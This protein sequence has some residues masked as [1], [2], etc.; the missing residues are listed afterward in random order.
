MKGRKLVLLVALVTDLLW[1]HAQST[2]GVT[3]VRDTSYST[4]REYQ[5]LKKD[6]P[7]ILV[8]A[9]LLSRS[10]T[11]KK[12]LVYCTVG[13]RNLKLDVFYPSP[14]TKEVRN[15]IVFIHG[16]GW[17]SGSK[18]QHHALAQ[19]LAGL[20]YVCFTPEYRLSTEALFPAAVHDLK[21]AVR[22][23]RS[24]AKA[25]GYNPD[26]IA[27]A[28][29]SAG[30]ELAAFIGNT[31]EQPAYEGNNCLPRISSTVQAILNLDG[32][33]SFVHPE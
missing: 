31:N 19:R 12:G 29:F 2:I 8:P 24:Q 5:K 28:G 23:V 25:Y 32:T 26:K 3:G 11:E 16:G 9:P 27:V 22:W 17:R 15:A 10:V 6:Y 21:T 20:G 18:E 1:S 33:L 30:G 7:Q 14:I 4:Q 13:S